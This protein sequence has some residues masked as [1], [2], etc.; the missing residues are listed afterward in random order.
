MKSILNIGTQL[1]YTLTHNYTQSVVTGT[2]LGLWKGLSKEERC[3][4]GFELK[5]SAR[6]D[7]TDF[8]NM[9]LNERF[10]EDFKLRLGIFESFSLE[11]RQVKADRLLPPGVFVFRTIKH[12]IGNVI[13]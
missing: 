4:L 13:Q 11:D 5:Q 8:E 3:E 10:P 6:G 7:F 9:R 12:V 1:V 2:V